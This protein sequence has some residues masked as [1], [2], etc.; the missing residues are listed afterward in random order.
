[1]PNSIPLPTAAPVAT[2]SSD[3][4]AQQIYNI[5]NSRGVFKQDPEAQQI[6]HILRARGV[7]SDPTQGGLITPQPA[8]SANATPPPPLPTKGP[9]VDPLVARMAAEV[10]MPPVQFANRINANN[11]AS[12]LPPRFTVGPDGSVN[13]LVEHNV[14]TPAA[15]K[16]AQP[17]VGGYAKAIGQGVIE[18][19]A[20]NPTNNAASAIG[21]YGKDVLKSG[22]NALSPALQ[23]PAHAVDA[24][25]DARLAQ[26]RTA[27]ANA[28]TPAQHAA[29]RAQLGQILAQ[30]RLPQN[31]WLQAAEGVQS[32]GESANQFAVPGAGIGSGIEENLAPAIT[33]FAAAME[34]MGSRG[35]NAAKN[36]AEKAY[37]GMEPVIPAEAMKHPVRT[38]EDANPA[39]EVTTQSQSHVQPQP[40]AVDAANSPVHDYIRQH[41]NATVD[42]V[43]AAHPGTPWGEVSQAY[44]DVHGAPN[45]VNAP[46]TAFPVTAK[47]QTGDKSPMLMPTKSDADV[48]QQI[49]GAKETGQADNAQNSPAKQESASAPEKVEPEEKQTARA[50][51]EP[52]IR[53]GYIAGDN[54]PSGQSIALKT[55][56]AAEKAK[57]AALNAP[58][59]AAD[60]AAQL[61]Q[62]GMITDEHIPAITAL[63]NARAD[64]W[65]RE[66]GR[67]A[68]E[69]VP[70]RFAGVTNKQ[71]GAAALRQEGAH[72]PQTETPEFK[73]GSK[74]PPTYYAAEDLLH[75]ETGQDTYKVNA[76]VKKLRSGKEPAPGI[77]TKDGNDTQLLD[78]HHRA[79]SLEQLGRD[80]P[81][82]GIRK[83]V[84]ESL[85]S[86]GHDSVDILAGVY[87]AAGYNKEVTY[88]DKKFPGGDVAKNSEAIAAEIRKDPTALFQ[89]DQGAMSIAKDGRAVIHALKS[90]NVSTAIHELFHVFRQDAAE[91]DVKVMGDWAGVKGGTWERSH[92]EAVARAFERYAR[93]GK[94]PIPALKEAFGNFKQWLTTIY[95]TIK[96]SPIDQKLT[97]ELRGAFDRML[98]NDGEAK[99][100]K[101]AGNA[102]SRARAEF[103]QKLGD[104]FKPGNIVKGY[105]R[106]RDRVISFQPLDEDGNWSVEVQEVDNNNK[107]IGNIRSHK[108]LPGARDLAGGPIETNS[109]TLNQAVPPPPLAA[110]YRVNM[111]SGALPPQQGGPGLARNIADIHAQ[112]RNATTRNLNQLRQLASPDTYNAAVRLGGATPQ[113]NVQMNGV[114]GKIAKTLN[115]QMNVGDFNKALTES[116]LMSG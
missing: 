95:S 43:A 59:D 27:Y 42:E 57:A 72:N 50:T 78:G 37:I 104:Y 69:Y 5:L 9:F 31:E 102:K 93:E 55:R 17:G 89:S 8:A 71:P 6:G 22:V 63:V 4:E 77:I 109:T 58:K 28:K 51:T 13:S 92:E 10:K 97:P 21:N 40:S 33:P 68:T 75:T 34:S 74:L 32:A 23:Y 90:P 66:T 67:P 94:A 2:A 60:L 41:P 108:T 110:Q 1:M 16:A 39:T 62:H 30:R 20:S 107:P 49:F 103:N 113:V 111:Q 24:I 105:G 81:T 19:L 65:A 100:A 79:L 45:Q 115:G 61:K 98:G 38:P 73:R 80:I 114:M 18:G 26:A 83:D 7:V 15:M 47:Q 46:V 99:V 56:M 3:P 53:E 25:S 88:L 86:Q 101:P 54:H 36:A 44:H 48:H 12:G 85:K 82:I 35:V 112:V 87:K 84:F 116:R 96:G 70:S 52:T 14:A 106:S 29:A 11:K 91:R 64:A 76:L